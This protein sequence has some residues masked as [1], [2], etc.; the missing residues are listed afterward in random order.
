[1]EKE[2]IPI[3]VLLFIRFL[4]VN[5]VYSLYRKKISYSSL[6]LFSKTHSFLSLFS[7]TDPELYISGFFIWSSEEKQMWGEI[8]KKWMQILK[9]TKL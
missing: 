9:K 1:M 4:K 5:K 7:R 2:K 8:N 6:A 3:V